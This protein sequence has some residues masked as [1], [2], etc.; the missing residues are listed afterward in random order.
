MG[1]SVAVPNDTDESVIE[2]AQLRWP[3]G[4]GIML[5]SSNRPGNRF[6]QRPTG[7]DSVYIVT[8]DPDAVYDRAVAAGAEVF[9]ELVEHDYDSRGFSVTDPEGN[10]WSFG[11]DGDE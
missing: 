7:A 5:G 9:A 1:G 2:H 6:S 3:D 8:A 11:A 4:G 10:I